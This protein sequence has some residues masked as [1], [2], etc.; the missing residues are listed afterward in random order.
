[1]DLI[2]R[3]PNTHLYPGLRG[4]LEGD[5]LPGAGRPS[6]CLV[7]FSDGNDQLKALIQKHKRPASLPTFSS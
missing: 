3:S 5:N 1:M 7:E 6:R 2:F 4:R